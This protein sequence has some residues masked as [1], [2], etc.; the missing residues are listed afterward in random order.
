MIAK[1]TLAFLLV[2]SVAAAQQSARPMP[3]ISYN[4]QVKPILANNCFR[5]HGPDEKARKGKLRL[6]LEEETKG[7]WKVGEKEDAEA[8]KRL[9][10]TDPD[11]VMPPPEAHS[12][13][14][15]ADR[16]LL[17]SWVAQGAKYERHWAFVPPVSPPVGWRGRMPKWRGFLVPAGRLKVIL[18]RLPL[19]AR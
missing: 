10:T 11:E 15:S 18:R 12:E 9:F 19:C 14:T 8:I 7:A 6:D 4:F 2:L 13:M 3:P 5:C 17:R 1:L 16:E